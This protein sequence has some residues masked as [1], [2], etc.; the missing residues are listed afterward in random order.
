[1]MCEKKTYLITGASSG[2]GYATAKLLADNGARVILVS[3]SLQKLN[4]AIDGLQGDNHIA[5]RYDLSD[6]DNIGT[7]FENITNQ[8]IKLS[9]L[10]HCAGVSPLCLIKDNSPAL[11][12][13]VFAINVFSLIELVKYFQREE[14]SID[15]AKIVSVASITAHG[16]GY[17]QTLY[18]SSKAAMLS[19]MKLMAKELLNRNIKINCVSPGV[20]DTP[21]LNSLRSESE[22]LEIKIRANQPLGIIPAEKVAD[23]INYLLGP[24]TDFLTGMEWFYDSGAM[25]K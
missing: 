5:I 18:G 13:K 22:N 2:I 12:Q 15:G 19:A 16:A 8:G 20:V 1:M 7:I 21:M 23:V 4:K 10:V 6:L 11:M 25:L 3:S 9:G 14:V 24:A 17:R